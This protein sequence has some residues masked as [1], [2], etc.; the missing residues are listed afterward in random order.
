MPWCLLTI[1]IFLRLNFEQIDQHCLLELAATLFG[2][3]NW[4]N[5]KRQDN[6]AHWTFWK[7]NARN[8]FKRSESGVT[9]CK[10]W[11]QASHWFALWC[12]TNFM[13]RIKSL[14]ALFKV[15]LSSLGVTGAMKA[16]REEAA[17]A[18]TWASQSSSNG[19][20]VPYVSS[21]LGS[22]GGSSNDSSLLL[23]DGEWHTDSS[24]YWPNFSEYPVLHINE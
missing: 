4:S 23:L 19:I 13:R 22:G 18:S 15:N 17:T 2:C 14:R 24:A 21:P 11:A 10:S 16:G 9:E 3:L 12:C 8:F 1:Y 7:W 6:V 5:S 20:S